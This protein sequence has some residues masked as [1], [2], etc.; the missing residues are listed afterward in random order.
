[1]KNKIFKK[2]I[3]FAVLGLLCFSLG[4]GQTSTET[5]NQPQTQNTTAV[6]TTV[7]TTFVDE[8]ASHQYRTFQTISWKKISR[9]KRYDVILQKKEKTEWV[10]VGKY[11]TE[12]TKLEFLLF[13]GDYRLAIN[14]I[15]VLGRVASKSDW[16]DF[17]V[18]DEKEPLFLD[19]KFELSKK[20]NSRSVPAVLTDS[21]T[22][23]F[24][25][26]GKNIFF[27]ETSFY[28]VPL[29]EKELTESDTF[30]SYGI[31]LKEVSLV[32]LNRDSDKNIVSV[33][34][35]SKNLGSGYYNLIAKNPSGDIDSIKILV[36][37]Q[38]S[39]VINVGSYP[40][41]NHLGVPS[42]LLDKTPKSSIIVKGFNITSE[43]EFLLLPAEKTT[44]GKEYPFSSRMEKIVVPLEFEK[45]VNISKE[46]ELTLS[47]VTDFEKLYTGF[48]ILQAKNPGQESVN[49]TYLFIM[50]DITK[51]VPQI[52]SAK[53]ETLETGE[54]VLLL[55][56]KNLLKEGS[57]C[58]IKPFSSLEESQ[59]EKLTL[60]SSS[61]DNKTVS[62][63]V[64]TQITPNVSHAVLFETKDGSC[65][66]T[67]KLKTNGK[68]ETKE[69]D[70][71]KMDLLFL[72]P[73]LND[74]SV[75]EDSSKPEN[76]IWKFDF[77][78]T[79]G[80]SGG[81]VSTTSNFINSLSTSS[82]FVQLDYRVFTFGWF[83]L[84]VNTNFFPATK[85][86]S[87]GSD[88]EFVFPIPKLE[89][90]LTLIAASGIGFRNYWNIPAEVYI[91]YK[92]GL[93]ICKYGRIEYSLNW[94]GIGNDY[95]YFEDSYRIGAEY[96]F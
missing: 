39:P 61:D 50:K 65:I 34:C 7:D 27:P 93:N 68:I 76:Q 43:T 63:V 94:F 72:P 32:A 16:V 38:V 47:F 67:I 42:I 60:F 96:K 73:V 21:E 8:D 40:L 71:K 4:F 81:L 19:E 57:C 51:N 86:L 91:P 74:L 95:M 18:L 90:Y 59:Q 24:D 56:G 11:S 87:L 33:S 88:L 1:M 54:I 15:N 25:V 35:E 12:E 83:G 84:G 29:K 92:I 52:D 85:I 17:I 82:W 75:S 2:K 22:F 30:S 28:L 55:N 89:K 26:F 48:Y 69:Y 70:S 20:Y 46:N 79:L 5:K 77:K 80:L 78:G 66:V 37:K 6:I 53:I 45:I 13:P 58:F 36:L 31:N 62:F 49:Q 44:D 3:V 64:K 9:A 23:T 10:E 14:V 41:N